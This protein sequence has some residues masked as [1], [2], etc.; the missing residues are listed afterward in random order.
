MKISIPI[1]NNIIAEFCNNVINEP[2]TFFSESD[3]QAILFKDLLVKFNKPISTSCP[4]G[5]KSK[6][7]YKTYQVHKEYG[8]NENPKSRIDI[9]VFD[10][11]GIKQIDNP[12]L[13][14]GKKYIKPIIGIELGT[15]KTSNQESHIL[16]DLGK[17]TKNNIKKGYLIY[18]IKDET[19]SSIR[20]ERGVKT[21]SKLIN[22][23]TIFERKYPPNV[24][25]I[26]FILKI[27]KQ[28]KR[29]WGKCEL[30]TN[31]NKWKPINLKD[32]KKRVKSYLASQL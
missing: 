3:L 4:R 2:L 24:I 5:D 22:F 25:P 10:E 15:H 26:I 28:Q 7:M 31:R 18:K 6:G 21:N 13:Q 30:Y 11:N 16:N 8:L 20:S 1:I 19:Y 12:N 32:I 9:A 14:K 27:T 23:K 29:I 17:M